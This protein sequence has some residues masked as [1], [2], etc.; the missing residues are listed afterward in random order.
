MY[1]NFCKA[2]YFFFDK[3]LLPLAFIVFLI[4]LFAALP[5]C[6]LMEI[7]NTTLKEAIIITAI[8]WGVMLLLEIITEMANHGEKLVRAEKDAKE[9]NVKNG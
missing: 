4:G 6:L 7:A 2:L 3:I 5:I 1:D 9:G 8:G